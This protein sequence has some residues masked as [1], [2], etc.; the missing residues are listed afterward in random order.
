MFPPIQHLAIKLEF[1]HILYYMDEKGLRNSML[2]D[3]PQYFL[4]DTRSKLLKAHV[5]ISRMIRR[6]NLAF[7]MEGDQYFLILLLPKIKNFISFED[8]H[9]IRNIHNPTFQ[10]KT[11]AAGCTLE[12]TGP[13]SEPIALKNQFIQLIIH[14]I[15]VEQNKSL[16]DLSLTKF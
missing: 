3:F 16:T 6:L 10:D 4:W 5:K 14:N 12:D 1:D 7:I 15:L 11:L 13:P 8:L 9:T 2:T